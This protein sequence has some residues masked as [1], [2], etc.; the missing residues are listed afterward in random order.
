MNTVRINAAPAGSKTFSAPNSRVS[1]QHVTRNIKPTVVRPS[2]V[3]F[4]LATPARTTVTLAATL[5]PACCRSAS[6][7][8]AALSV[9]SVC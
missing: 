5:R 2:G 6:S 3:Y 7:Y 4:R 9:M 1:V 8:W